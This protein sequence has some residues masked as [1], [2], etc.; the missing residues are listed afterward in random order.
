MRN[1]SIESAKNSS[2]FAS[3]EKSAAKKNISLNGRYSSMEEFVEKL[4]TEMLFHRYIHAIDWQNTA[5]SSRVIVS[6]EAQ[7]VYS[8]CE[9]W[10]VEIYGLD[11]FTS[12]E[13]AR[14][15][16]MACSLIKARGLSHDCQLRGA[17]KLWLTSEKADLDKTAQRFVN[18]LRDNMYYIS[19]LLGL[20]EDQDNEVINLVYEY[21]CSYRWGQNACVEA[22]SRVN[23]IEEKKA[24]L[25]A[26]A[27]L[28]EVVEN[29]TTSE[30]IK[31]VYDFMYSRIPEGAFEEFLKERT[32]FYE[33]ADYLMRYSYSSEAWKDKLWFEYRESEYALEGILKTI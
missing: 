11:R 2:S 31:L 17:A 25:F 8:S 20:D 19:M 21:I 27:S 30:Y 28:D 12:I 5:R 16:I 15:Y 18:N 26:F 3:T 4:S 32:A 7:D 13:V 24:V 23:T 9:N 6:V 1:T 14:A 29:P 33:D 22:V 10:N